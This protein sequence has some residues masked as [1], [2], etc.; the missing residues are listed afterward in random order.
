MIHN[1]ISPLGARLSTALRYVREGAVLADIGTDHAYLPI[2]LCKKGIIR[3]A[4]AADIAEGPLAIATRHIGEEG[5]SERIATCLSDGLDKLEEYRPT[6]ITIY[7]MGGELIADILSRAPWTRDPNIRLILQPMT[8]MTE[9]RS[10]LAENGYH[11]IDECLSK[12]SGRIYQTICAEYDGALRCFDPLTLAYGEHILASHDPLLAELFDRE[13]AILQNIIK[14]KKSA[15]ANADAERALLEAII[16]YR[17]G[18]A[19]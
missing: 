10:F 6:D 18:V 13:Q 8:K 11:I 7:G 5:L 4:V 2:C 17:K 3:T 14:G 19:L 16:E 12:D 15:D 1:N 9:L